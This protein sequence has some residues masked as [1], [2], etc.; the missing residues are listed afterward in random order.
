M[1]D[2][3]IRKYDIRGVVGKNLQISDGYEIGRKFGQAVTNILSSKPV[4]DEKVL[5]EEK[6]STAEY[7]N[8]FE[9][10]K[11]S[12]TTKLPSEIEF[13][14]KSNVCVGYD[15]RIHSPNI[16]QELIRGLTSAGANVLRI[17]LCSSPMLYAATQITQADLGIIITAS[18]N[19]SEYNGFKFF[20]NNKV[21]SDQEIKEVINNPIKDSTK[22]GSVINV[23]IYDQYI[24][25]LKNAVK[26]HNQQKLKI[27]WDCGNSPASGIIRYIENILLLPGHTHII[28]N[29][30]IDGTFPLHDPDPIEEKNLTHLIEIVKKFQCDLGIALDG[31]GDRVRLIDNKGNVVSSDHLFMLF[32]Q[33]VLSEYPGSKVIA[34]IKMSMKVHNFVNELG[35]QVITCATG[36]SLVKKEMI[37]QNAKFAGELSGHFFFSELGFDDGLYSAI[38]AVDIL[39][40]K[41]QSLFEIIGELPKLYVTHEIKIEVNDEKKFQIIE[42]IKKTLEQQNITFSD[43]DGVK[44]NGQCNKFWWLLRA[45]NTQNCITARCEGDTLENF[46]LTKKVLFHYLDEVRSLNLS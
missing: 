22:A 19:P 38:K 20:S 1:D 15:S 43:L 12:S 26:N 27:A 41:Q 28:T 3:I 44:V 4:Y 5:G 11:Q 46:E 21:F 2:K 6:M 8:V 23:N 24:K 14:R 37:K 33:E 32:A 25:I 16:E 42:S 29:N 18:H 9:E 40:K 34:N 45:S 31:D 13:Q 17:G 36:H 10:R 30:S 35:G 7:L 39:L